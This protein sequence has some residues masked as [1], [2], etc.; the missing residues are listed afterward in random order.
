MKELAIQMDGLLR[1]LEPAV[2]RAD[3]LRFAVDY[4]RVRHLHRVLLRRLID[5][6]DP[7]GQ[8]APA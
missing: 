3:L 5:R 4:G 8:V 1:S 6:L 7:S 2:S